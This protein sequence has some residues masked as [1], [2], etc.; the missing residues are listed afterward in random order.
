MVRASYGDGD[1]GSYRWQ[2][3][4]LEILAQ[5]GFQ[6]PWVFLPDFHRNEKNLF[7]KNKFARLFVPSWTKCVDLSSVRP[8]HKLLYVFVPTINFEQINLMAILTETPDAEQSFRIF[9]AKICGSLQR[10]FTKIKLKT[11]HSMLELDNET[12]KFSY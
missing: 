3:F 2:D 1:G 5:S 8:T 9:C 11:F 12:V 10:N 4:R 7:Y 6:P